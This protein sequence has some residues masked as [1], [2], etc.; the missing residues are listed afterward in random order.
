MSCYTHSLEDFD[1][2][3]RRPP[4]SMD[5]HPLWDLGYH[6]IGHRNPAFSSSRI[7]V[8][9]T[10]NGPLRALDTVAWLNKVAAPS[11]LFKV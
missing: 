6:T 5:Q 1:F 9:L 10:K 7:A 8:L 3:D 11:H 4:I 2:H